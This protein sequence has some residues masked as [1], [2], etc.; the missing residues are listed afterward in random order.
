MKKHFGRPK[1]HDPEIPVGSENRV[2]VLP[3]V[4]PG[5]NQGFEQ[6]PKGL[7]T[8]LL[9]IQI[10]G[11]IHCQSRPSRLQRAVRFLVA[12][13]IV[14]PIPGEYISNTAER[15]IRYTTI[16]TL[17]SSGHLGITVT[18]IELSSPM[19]L[20][21]VCRSTARSTYLRTTMPTNRTNDVVLSKR[22][23]PVI[24]ILKTTS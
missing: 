21:P 22:A 23:A 17:S 13:P 10:P 4:Q 9:P 8:S 15:D 11:T 19:L 1:K 14:P 20:G 12:V 5:V 6:P 3:A 24:L 7:V 16:A 18:P 2:Q